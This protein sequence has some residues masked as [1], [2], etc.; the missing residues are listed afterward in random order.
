MRI[1][2]E[3]LTDRLFAENP[4][5][6]FCNDEGAGQTLVHPVSLLP[7]SDAGGRLIACKFLLADQS[8]LRGYLG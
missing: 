5:W 8:R 3:K 7:I 1:P 4:V 2:V 6:E